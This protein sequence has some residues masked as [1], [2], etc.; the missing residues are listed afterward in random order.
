MGT[1]ADYLIDQ[2]FDRT[3]GEYGDELPSPPI[4]RLSVKG[5]NEWDGENM[6]TDDSGPY[7][8]FAE[9]GPLQARVRTLERLLNLT[10]DDPSWPNLFF[11]QANEIERLQAEANL[12][13]QELCEARGEIERLNRELLKLKDYAQAQEDK[14]EARIKELE[15]A[16][17]MLTTFF[18]EGWVMPLGWEQMVAQAKQ[19]LK[20]GC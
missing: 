8:R 1:E 9:V 3:H 12:N 5:W 4:E 13:M 2:H 16:I 11:Q 14:Y 19:V 10:P 17:R 15:G 6:E 20:G 7:V 18:P